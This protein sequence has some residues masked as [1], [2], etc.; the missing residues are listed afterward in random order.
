M[1]ILVC[2]GRNYN[3]R[4][5]VFHELHKLAEEHGWLTIIQGGASGADKLARD[6]AQ[7]CYHGLVLLLMLIGINMVRALDLD[8]MRR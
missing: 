4:E 8:A 2:G 5:I 3:N 1:R 6:W 7:E